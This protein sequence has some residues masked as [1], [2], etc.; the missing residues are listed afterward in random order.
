MGPASL[1]PCTARATDGGM[2]DSFAIVMVRWGRTW[3]TTTVPTG[4]SAARGSIP[5]TRSARQGVFNGGCTGMSSRVGWRELWW[6]SAGGQLPRAEGVSLLTTFNALYVNARRNRG[7][8][9]LVKIS[10]FASKWQDRAHC[11]LAH[12]I[13]VQGQRLKDGLGHRVVHKSHFPISDLIN[14][15]RIMMSLM[16]SMSWRNISDDVRGWKTRQSGTPASRP[17]RQACWVD[18]AFLQ[19]QAAAGGGHPRPGC[20]WPVNGGARRGTSPSEDALGMR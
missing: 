6:R 7:K 15:S 2:V 17:H 13:A 12:V 16:M 19:L 3:G 20:V 9:A 8:A 5:R 11:L 10:H 18:L 14:T 1:E 4:C